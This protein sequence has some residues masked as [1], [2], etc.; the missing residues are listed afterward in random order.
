MQKECKKTVY[1][2]IVNILNPTYDLLLSI[3]LEF[4]NMLKGIKNRLSEEEDKMLQLLRSKI[5]D[6]LA[7][8]YNVIKYFAMKY[9][10]FEEKKAKVLDNKTLKIA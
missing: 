7:F 4:D 6:L 10:I 8:Y 9:H 5:I 2:Q 1:E 3:F